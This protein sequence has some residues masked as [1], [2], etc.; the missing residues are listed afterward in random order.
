M[1]AI[2]SEPKVIV[3]DWKDSLR[4]KLD[5]KT[6]PDEFSN[7]YWLKEELQ[8][9]CKR[10]NLSGHGSKD[11][12]TKRVFMYLKT[13]EIIFPVKGKNSKSISGKI[14]LSLDATIPE[15]YKSDEKHR[16]F[17]KSHIGQHFKFNVPFMD[18]MK[19]N[20][21]KTYKEAVT[22]WNRIT[23]DK[24]QGKKTTISSQF[25]YNQYIREFFKANP[26]A[27]MEDAIKCW[28]FRKSLPGDNKYEAGDLHALKQ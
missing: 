21:G 22:E 3:S 17:F 14:P 5:I 16:A 11:D 13:G 19:N 8:I 7:Y 4:P 10:Y 24:K 9:F 12:L 18:W 23:Q 1:V 26:T 27:I 15:N 28:K 2:V 25:Q 6:D 20:A